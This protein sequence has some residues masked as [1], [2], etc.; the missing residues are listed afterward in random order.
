MLIGLISKRR[1][2]P[3]R[4]VEIDFCG[5]VD[6]R[7]VGI[8]VNLRAVAFGILATVT[9]SSITSAQEFPPP[10]EPNPFAAPQAPSGTG[11]WTFGAGASP[12]VTV[13]YPA[14]DPRAGRIQQVVVGGS[15]DYSNANVTTVS[16]LGPN[17]GTIAFARDTITATGAGLTA[18][19]TNQVTT[20]CAS[21]P[22][23]AQQH[24]GGNLGFSNATN[25]ARTVI[26]YASNSAADFVAANASLYDAKTVSL[27]S[28][29]AL[30]DVNGSLTNYSITGNYNVT[31]GRPLTA[32]T[33]DDVLHGRLNV[34]QQAV[35]G[36]FQVNPVPALGFTAQQAANL[37]GFNNFNYVQTVT[38]AGTYSEESKTLT[39]HFSGPVFP[40]LPNQIGNVDPLRGGNLN[41]PADNFDPYWDQVR[42][43]G[44]SRVEVLDHNFGLEFVDGTDLLVAG[45]FITF[46]TQLVG[47][48][49]TS[50][51]DLTFSPLTLTSDGTVD[52]TLTF[53][54]VYYQVLN[55]CSG[56]ISG[57]GLVLGGPSDPN[58]QPFGLSFL[59][60]YGDMTDQQIQNAIADK[61]STL[62]DYDSLFQTGVPEPST[63]AMMFVGFAG[64]GFMAH[65]RKSKSAL[66][67]A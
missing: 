67:A 31:F 40:G 61:F 27:S 65:R 35:V 42:L 4:V 39:A 17:P 33:S 2:R 7:E 41:L 43:P 12:S 64:L 13:T 21:A 46:R 51:S 48:T 8:A 49:Q 59:L 55:H 24:F 57:C 25:L 14:I 5:G 44:Q 56:T 53:N 18:T 37:S 50:T 30:T 20:F 15:T 6:K 60:G 3:W 47:V 26:P 66:M 19:N 9:T 11:T 22:C 29:T 54:W 36:G 63:W 16:T 62:S 32:W 28:S 58:A 23:V 10:A 1:P 34:P 38:S 45:R 52:P